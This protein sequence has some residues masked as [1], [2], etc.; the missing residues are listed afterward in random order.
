MVKVAVPGDPGVKP[1]EM[2]H[3]ADL[4]AQPW[5]NEGRWGIA[6]RATAIRSMPARAE[7]AAA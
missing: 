1:G 4:T 2:V 3:A 5:E 7:K 6:Y